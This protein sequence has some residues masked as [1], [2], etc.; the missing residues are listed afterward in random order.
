MEIF[1][2]MISMERPSKRRDNSNEA[3]IVVCAHLADGAASIG[4]IC[5][6]MRRNQL[7]QDLAPDALLD[8]LGDL[9]R[10]GLARAWLNDNV[11][12]HPRLVGNAIATL[13]AR[14]YRSLADLSE[15]YW[16][17][18][19]SGLVFELTEAGRTFVRDSLNPTD[20]NSDRWVVS[21]ADESGT[22]SVKAGSVNEA[23]TGLRRWLVLNPSRRLIPGSAVWTG[24]PRF[25][26]RTGLPVVNGVVV[27]AQTVEAVDTDR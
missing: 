3:H 24:A 23:L 22:L 25:L 8:T 7:G 1:K 19:E 10:R 21:F 12:E 15:D 11:D 6:E 20:G 14:G 26:T 13:R 16:C 2:H 17:T 27:I 4:S 5:L 9:Q 18:D